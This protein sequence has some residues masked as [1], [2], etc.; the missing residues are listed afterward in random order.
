M[1]GE[2]NPS[3]KGGVS[4]DNMRYKKRQVERFPEKIRCRRRTAYLITSGRIKRWP[5]KVCGSLDTHAHH[6]DYSDPF[7]VEWYCRKHHR[8]LHGQN[9]HPKNTDQEL[10]NHKKKSICGALLCAKKTCD[11]LCGPSGFCNKHVNSD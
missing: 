11:R 7:A 3:W 1:V 4:K 5:C 2:N 8:D 6:N 9:G 10:P